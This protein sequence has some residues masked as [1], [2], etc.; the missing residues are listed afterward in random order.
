MGNGDEGKK[1]LLFFWVCVRDL[2]MV[3]TTQ[4]IEG[5]YNA[6][7]HLFFFIFSIVAKSLRLRGFVKS[8]NY[9]ETKLV[10]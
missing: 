3:G 9:R 5:S 4:G 8:G 7:P 2:T 6:G 10:S 1:E